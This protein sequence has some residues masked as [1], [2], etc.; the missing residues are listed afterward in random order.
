MDYGP[1]CDHNEPIRFLDSTFVYVIYKSR[2]KVY[3]T[4]T[5]SETK[6]VKGNLWFTFEL[7]VRSIEHQTYN[8]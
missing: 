6:V 4:N 2:I 5:L 8:D 1:S 7:K 3:S